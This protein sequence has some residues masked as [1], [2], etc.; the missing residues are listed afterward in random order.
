[1][2]VNF[3]ETLPSQRRPALR[4]ELVPLDRTIEKLYVLAKDLQLAR[5]PD[6]QGLAGSSHFEEVISADETYLDR[7]GNC[8]Y[9]DEQKRL[10]RVN[11][12]RSSSLVAKFPKSCR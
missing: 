4:E 7:R 2:I 9:S 5:V 3:W 10:A 6:P 1:M 11:R 12:D 8:R